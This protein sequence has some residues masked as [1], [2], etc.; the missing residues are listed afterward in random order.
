MTLQD[1]STTMTD[2]SVQQAIDG[3]LS[4]LTERVGARLR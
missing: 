2:E 1:V 3:V 4:D